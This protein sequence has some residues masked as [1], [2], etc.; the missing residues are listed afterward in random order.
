VDEC[1]SLDELVNTICEGKTMAPIFEHAETF[2]MLS[3]KDLLTVKARLKDCFKRQFSSRDF[4]A[5]I[6]DLQSGEN[7]PQQP[8]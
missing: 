8:F 3:K 5:A 7:C 2:A 6:K 1:T 4:D